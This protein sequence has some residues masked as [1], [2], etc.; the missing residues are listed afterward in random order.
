ML[1]SRL[2]RERGPAL[3]LKKYILFLLCSFGAISHVFLTVEIIL[4]KRYKKGLMTL[5]TETLLTQVH[6][7][8]KS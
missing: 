6:L 1:T 8:Q 5:Q 2:K 7:K 3:K 4:D